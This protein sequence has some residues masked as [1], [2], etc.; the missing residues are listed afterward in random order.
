MAR[1]RRKVAKWSG[2]SADD[3][4]IRQDVSLIFEVVK[5]KTGYILGARE[6]EWRLTKQA[7]PNCLEDFCIAAIQG[8]MLMGKINRSSQAVETAV[9]EALARLKSH[10][11]KVK[12]GVETHARRQ[13][14]L[15]RFTYG[16]E[17]LVFAHRL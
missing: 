8:G 15:I 3:E 1:I 17:L 4:L 12:H 16:R 2:L 6:S 7:A 9:Q 10:V 5:N 11:V 13:F 14:S